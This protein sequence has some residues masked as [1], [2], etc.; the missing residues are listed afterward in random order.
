M[1]TKPGGDTPRDD[2]WS[3]KR[4]APVD[5]GVSKAGITH[6]NFGQGAE[7]GLDDHVN[8]ATRVSET[9]IDVVRV[10]NKPEI[11]VLG[12]QSREDE[13]NRETPV[14]EPAWLEMTPNVP[15]Q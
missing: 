5:E 4:D 6:P 9:E 1:L 15:E 2:T 11:T 13:L 14:A 12:W 7:V 3:V 8:R 10:D